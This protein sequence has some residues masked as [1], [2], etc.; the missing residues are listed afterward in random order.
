MISILPTLGY[1]LDPPNTGSIQMMFLQHFLPC[2]TSHPDSLTESHQTEPDWV[3]DDTFTE[4]HL[5]LSLA[6]NLILR[7][8]D[9]LQMMSFMRIAFDASILI[10]NISRS[11][12]N[13]G[14]PGHRWYVSFFT[15]ESHFPLSLA[16][17]LISLS[18]PNWVTDDG[19]HANHPPAGKVTQSQGLVSLV[20]NPSCHAIHLLIHS[21]LGL[22]LLRVKF[23]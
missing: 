15:A 1:Y 16:S 6:S 3:T 22:A 17:N 5:L 9:G 10:L 12:P 21:H 8:S 14:Q 20:G 13:W 7:V 18:K 19:F 11:K 23:D 4:S 2:C